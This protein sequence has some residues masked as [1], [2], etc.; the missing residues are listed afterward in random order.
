MSALGQKRTC[1]PSV[2]TSALPPKADI[3]RGHA[4]AART[5]HGCGLRGHAR[6]AGAGA[7]RR[8]ATFVVNCDAAQARRRAGPRSRWHRVRLRCP[9]RQR[10][11]PDSRPDSRIIATRLRPTHREAQT[12]IAVSRGLGL[13]VAAESMGVAL[14][15]ARSHLRQVFAKT[16]TSQQAELAALVHRTLT[17]VRHGR[18]GRIYAAPH[19]GRAPVQ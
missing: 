7:W 14:T 5:G 19:V 1:W 10:S 2:P 3:A 6:P 13:N 4:S 16:G 15:T 11:G 12:A 18:L 9:L 17:L 8:D